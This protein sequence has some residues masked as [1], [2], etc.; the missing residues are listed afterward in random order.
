MSLSYL[1]TYC[2]ECARGGGESREGDPSSPFFLLS[3]FR[4]LLPQPARM[5]KSWVIIMGSLSLSLSLSLLAGRFLAEDCPSGGGRARANGIVRRR[6][7]S[8]PYL[9]LS[10]FCSVSTYTTAS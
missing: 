8:S 1:R 9:L 10:Q 4:L 2:C 3:Y 7:F 5:R 6:P